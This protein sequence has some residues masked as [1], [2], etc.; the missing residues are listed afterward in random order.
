MSVVQPKNVQ[1]L[2]NRLAAL[3]D[4]AGIARQRGLEDGRFDAFI[5]AEK[6]DVNVLIAAAMADSAEGPRIV[7]VE[8]GALYRKDAG[9]PEGY[10]VV[11]PVD[12][13]TLGLDAKVIGSLPVDQP[14]VEQPPVDQPPAGVPESTP[15]P[16]P[17]EAV[18]IESGSLQL[19]G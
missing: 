5:A 11:S 16:A 10:R 14:P 18:A 8:G 19:P 17:T 4:F 2:F 9:V 1:D 3:D 12:A 13:S 6:S 7:Q 15:I